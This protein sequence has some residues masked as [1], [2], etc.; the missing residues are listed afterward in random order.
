M[1]DVEASLLRAIRVISPSLLIISTSSLDEE[2]NDLTLDV[3]V[4]IVVP[5]TES[6]NN[7][8]VR[9]PVLDRVI[10]VLPPAVKK[11]INQ[12]DRI[13]NNVIHIHLLKN[14]HNYNDIH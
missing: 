12:R 14:Q 5:I 10:I 4:F 3:V 9:E 11:A 13:P 6:E 7:F 2:F 1:D 8:G